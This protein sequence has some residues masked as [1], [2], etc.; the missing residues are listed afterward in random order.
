M[1]IDGDEDSKEAPVAAE[2]P[3]AAAA[4]AAGPEDI[5]D[6]GEDLRADLGHLGLSDDEAVAAQ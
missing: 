4:P 1:V 2:A 5:E 6:G 3:A